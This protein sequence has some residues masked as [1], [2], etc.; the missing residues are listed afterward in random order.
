MKSC[1]L[2]KRKLTKA[3][4]QFLEITYMCILIRSKPPFFQ[5]PQSSLGL[6]LDKYICTPN[7]ILLEAEASSQVHGTGTWVHGWK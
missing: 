4:G 3:L 2:I 7:N 6:L 1:V 5:S